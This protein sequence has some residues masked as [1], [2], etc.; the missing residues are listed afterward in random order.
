MLLAHS[1]LIHK[2]YTVNRYKQF[3]GTSI[4]IGNDATPEGLLDE[5][6]K[7]GKGQ[8]WLLVLDDLWLPEQ[9][10]MLNCVDPSTESG[11]LITTRYE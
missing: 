4:S 8:R 3:T 9:F 10:R 1:L 5:L 11:V 6:C 2:T 7:V